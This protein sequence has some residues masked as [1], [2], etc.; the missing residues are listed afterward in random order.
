[1]IKLCSCIIVLFLIFGGCA[2]ILQS[3]EEKRLAGLEFERA[4]RLE[5]ERKFP[6]ATQEYLALTQKYP[7]TKIAL[8]ASLKTA[9]L[10]SNFNNP[11]MDI[12][13][14]FAWYRKI[15][16]SDVSAAEQE[17]VAHSLGLVEQILE[18]QKEMA[19]AQKENGLL[20]AENRQLLLGNNNISAELADK[21][22]QIEALESQ[23]QQVSEAL[24]KMKEIDV[25]LSKSRRGQ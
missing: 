17:R 10:Y 2:P 8:T 12:Q 25:N 7:S 15:L 11:E 5:D 16:N 18:L 13:K 20:V 24:A 21:K 3:F 14:A 19:Q 6:E 9:A 22:L 23:L 1:M 4:Q